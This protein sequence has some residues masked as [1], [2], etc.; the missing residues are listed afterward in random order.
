MQVSK[1]HR[2]N[3]RNPTTGELLENREQVCPA[4]YENFGSTGAGD[5]HRTGVFGMD[6]RCLPPDQV[7]LI[8]TPNSFGTEIWEIA[9]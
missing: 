7:G 9:E 8:R 3:H 6:R 1:A 4:C 5:R 2:A